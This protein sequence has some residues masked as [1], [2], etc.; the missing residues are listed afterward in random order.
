MDWI[1]NQEIVPSV[2]VGHAAQAYNIN[3]INAHE[4]VTTKAILEDIHRGH[5]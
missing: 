5:T 3:L 1:K 4:Q 2:F